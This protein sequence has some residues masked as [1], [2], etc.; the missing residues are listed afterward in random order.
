MPL[1]A[2]LVPLDVQFDVQSTTEVPGLTYEHVVDDDSFTH[3]VTAE[4]GV[5]S[6]IVIPNKNMPFEKY[7]IVS[8]VAGPL[9][10]DAIRWVWLNANGRLDSTYFMI[11]TYAEIEI[12]CN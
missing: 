10:I 12:K 11:D 1:I 7:I 9:C 2:T 3:L 8:P 5:Q 4:A 6:A